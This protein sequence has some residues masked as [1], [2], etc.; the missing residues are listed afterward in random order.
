MNQTMDTNK[1]RNIF[2]ILLLTTLFFTCDLCASEKKTE[3]ELNQE[4][5]HSENNV[6]NEMSEIDYIGND[7]LLKPVEKL[8][9][10]TEDYIL[11]NVGRLTH[12]DLEVYNNKMSIFEHKTDGPKVSLTF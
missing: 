8:K 9:N 12:D 3:L 6:N 7:V 4:I 5:F 11:F 1:I 10:N 2:I